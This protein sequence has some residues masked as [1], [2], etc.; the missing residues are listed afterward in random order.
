MRKTPKR[1]AICSRAGR[2]TLNEDSAT[3]LALRRNHFAVAVADGIGG[4]RAGDVASQTAIAAFEA[5]L[6]KEEPVGLESTLRSAFAAASAAVTEVA[7]CSPDHKGMG[8]TFVAALGD[9]ESVY[10]AHAGDSRAVLVLPQRVVR[11]TEDHT[12]AAEALRAG[13][14]TEA[15]A[16]NHPYRHAVTRSLGEGPV[17]P[18]LQRV[19]PVL[20]SKNRGALLLLGSDGLFNFLSDA[21]ILSAFRL[22]RNLSEAVTALVQRALDNGSDD[23]ATGAAVELSPWPW[24][25][26]TGNLV[27]AALLAVLALV[28][29]GSL[30]WMLW[31]QAASDSARAPLQSVAHAAPAPAQPQAP[32]QRT[33]EPA[34]LANGPQVHPPGWTPPHREEPI[35]PGQSSPAARMNPVAPKPASN[36]AP[37]RREANSKPE[38][39]LPRPSATPLGTASTTNLPVAPVVKTEAAAEVAK[40]EQA[41]KLQTAQVKVATLEPSPAPSAQPLDAA[42]V[43]RAEPLPSEPA[44]QR[45]AGSETIEPKEVRVEYQGKRSESVSF[46]LNVYSGKLTRLDLDGRITDE[47]RSSINTVLERQN[48]EAISD[49]TRRPFSGRIRASCSI[50]RGNIAAICRFEIPR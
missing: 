37:N 42:P 10:V 17:E 7:S 5:E 31:P 33:A 30:A 34:A 49:G 26:K 4:H 23:N 15:E 21:E 35:A 48:F 6:T 36:N 28:I 46:F 3:T 32:A 38:P 1:L 20:W 19:P 24:P 8:T 45:E 9:N 47:L 12:A 13:T 2:R 43:P 29:T 11:L 16:L 44:P 50:N 39:E 40:D 18:D 27:V 25:R 22:G 14:I 41:R